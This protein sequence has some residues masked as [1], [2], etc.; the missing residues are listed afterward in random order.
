[1]QDKFTPEL[2]LILLVIRDKPNQDK[3]MA[4]ISQIKW[5]YLLQLI[6]RHRLI[7]PLYSALQNISRVPASFLAQL[8]QLNHQMKINSLRLSA[9][10][11]RIV[12]VFERESVPFIIVKGI[13][14]AVNLYGGSDKR[15]CKDVDIWVSTSDLERA[16]NLL[17]ELGYI[18]MRPEYKLVGLKKKFYLNHAHEIALVNSSR[19]V[20]VELHFK[21]ESV[22]TNFFSFDEVMTQSIF[23]NQ[24]KFIT[25][26]DNYHFLYLMLHGAKHAWS[27]LRWLNDIALY[28]R[29]DK[30]DL[31][32]VYSLSCDLKCEHLFMQSLWLLRDIYQISDE[33]IDQLL[34]HIDARALNLADFAKRFICA[35]FVFIGDGYVFKSMFWKYRYYQIILNNGLK[36]FSAVW[37]ILFNLDLVFRVV[38]LPRYCGFAY[39][40][41]YPFEVMRHFILR[42][43]RK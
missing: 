32:L 37:D 42:V 33:K 30:C 40:I 8:K 29:Q 25:L 38:N 17:Q 23:I 19:L 28:I 27:R 34:T 15:Q 9:E 6:I 11:I 20:E 1:M 39:Y 16:E 18:T 35:D 4:L 7:D 36:R 22:G 21:L 43:F 12:R 10:A 31:G 5:D 13:P 24:Q 2:E 3:L 26:E 41:L 14:L